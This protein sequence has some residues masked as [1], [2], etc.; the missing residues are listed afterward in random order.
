MPIT[1]VQNLGLA[2]AATSATY[3]TLRAVCR[4]MSGEARQV[5]AAALASMRRDLFP[6][7]DAFEPTLETM[8]PELTR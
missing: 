2:D 5:A 4:A 1:L 7:A 8:N 3:R 6:R